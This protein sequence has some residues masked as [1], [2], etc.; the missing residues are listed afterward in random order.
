VVQKVKFDK[1]DMPSA[2]RSKNVFRLRLILG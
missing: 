1:T 2:L